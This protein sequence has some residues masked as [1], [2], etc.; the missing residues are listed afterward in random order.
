MSG[1]KHRENYARARR[2]G[3]AAGLADRNS[4]NKTKCPYNTGQRWMR[5]NG[6]KSYEKHGEYNE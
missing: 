4:Q 2:E 5:L 6:I 3:N 1:K